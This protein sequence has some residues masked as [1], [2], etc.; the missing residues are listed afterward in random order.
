M[1]SYL[2]ANPSAGRHFVGLAELSNPDP[3]PRDGEKRDVG[4]GEELMVVMAMV[5]VMENDASRHHGCVPVV[6]CE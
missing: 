4:E 1:D 3:E 6:V 2:D 5:M